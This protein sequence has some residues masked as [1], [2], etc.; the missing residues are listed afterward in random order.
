MYPKLNGALT[1]CHCAS[2]WGQYLLTN[3]KISFYIS[4]FSLHGFW[5]KI[6]T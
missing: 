5:L 2:V 1:Q 3:T 6:M 4:I